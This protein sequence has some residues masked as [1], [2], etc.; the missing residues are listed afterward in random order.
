[1][2]DFHTIDPSICGQSLIHKRKHFGPTIMQ[3]ES[4]AVNVSKESV[5]IKPF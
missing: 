1:M 5:R 3:H 4:Q 2:K